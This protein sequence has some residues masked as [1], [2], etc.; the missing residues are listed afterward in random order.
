MEERKQNNINKRLYKV[1]LGIIKVIPM[2]LAF[3]SLSNT[4]FDYF[5]I[6]VPILSYIGSVSLLTLTLLYLISY[7]FRFCIYHRLFLHYILVNNILCIIEYTVGIP[8]SDRG[9]LA[10]ILIIAGIFLFLILHYYRKEQ[11]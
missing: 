5:N 2:L 1:T 4:L 8:V 6:I 10:L 9:L 11:C 7:V 3:C